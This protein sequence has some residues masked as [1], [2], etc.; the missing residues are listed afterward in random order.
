M[1]APG[2]SRLRRLRS[3]LVAALGLAACS[4]SNS[5]PPASSET[6]P[7]SSAEAPSTA[8]GAPDAQG[9]PGAPETL[10]AQALGQEDPVSGAVVPPIVGVVSS[11]L[12]LTA[13]LLVLVACIAYVFGVAVYARGE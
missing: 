4:P 1:K 2:P 9:A 5:E 10:A 13:S 8:P 11:A 6:T 7:P 12:G 3:L